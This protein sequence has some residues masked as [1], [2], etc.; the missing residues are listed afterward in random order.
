MKPVCVPAVP[1]HPP[2]G[3]RQQHS[4]TGFC[5]LEPAPVGGQNAA[6]A[7]HAAPGRHRLNI[8]AVESVPHSFPVYVAPN[9]PELLGLGREQIGHADNAQAVQALFHA[10][11]NAGNIIQRDREQGT[12]H[13]GRI[14]DRYAIGLVPRA[15][16]FREHPVRREADGA[17]DIRSDILP[18]ACLDPL[19]QAA[20][21][22]NGRF[23]EAARQL[24]Y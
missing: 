15:G 17:G 19:R 20:R 14:P 8:V 10:S 6:M 5:L 3:L 21:V 18:Q 2:R 4:A 13:V 16:H 11:A 22:G 23:V 12:G 24:V 7:V 9:L 1:A